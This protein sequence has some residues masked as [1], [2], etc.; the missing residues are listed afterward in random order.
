MLV[1]FPRSTASQSGQREGVGVRLILEI[2]Q[3]LLY[4]TVY[5]HPAFERTDDLLRE[6]RPLRVSNP[7][8]TPEDS[9]PQASHGPATHPIQRVLRGFVL[10]LGLGIFLLGA[11]ADLLR[12]SGHPGLGGAQIGLMLIGLAFLLLSYALRF[13]STQ[14]ALPPLSRSSWKAALWTALWKTGLIAIATLL[15]IALSLEAVL[16]IRGAQPLYS[17]DSGLVELS[18]ARWWACDQLGCRFDPDQ[19]RDMPVAVWEETRRPAAKIFFDRL[20]VV[21][22]Q[23][24][25]D[26]DEFISSEELRKSHKIL[27]LGDSFAFGFYARLGQSWVE[28]LTTYLEPAGDLAV[29]NTGIPGA[30]TVQE[31]SI[32][33]HYFPIMLPDLVILGFYPG[34]DLDGN[35]HPADNF[36]ATENGTLFLSD[37]VGPGFEPIRM[38]PAD[39]YYRATGVRALTDAGT[40]ETRLGKTRAGTLLLNRWSKLRPEI[41]W[42]WSSE[43]R[44]SPG[45]ELKHKEI[46]A[47]TRRLLGGVRD[48]ITQRGSRLLLLLIPGPNDLADTGTRYQKGKRIAQDLSIEMVEVLDHLAPEDYV[49]SDEHWNDRGH[50]KVAR[51]LAEHIRPLPVAPVASSEE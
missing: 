26:E 28:L 7:L 25:H 48:F 35:L 17:P 6:I 14:A 31:L 33:E 18:L 47:R 9:R 45:L 49:P 40:V 44:W 3:R 36:Y 29:W 8:P 2:A 15:V 23:G 16:T 21:N 24:F 10:L 41:E 4:H 20:S 11:T 38:T 43:A 34:N 50:D 27:I 22:S 13:R 12:S 51:L 30:S 46:E 1:E 37:K 39:A 32:L 5:Y 19:P 42:M